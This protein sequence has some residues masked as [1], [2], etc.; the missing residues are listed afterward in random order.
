MQEIS[1]R[2]SMPWTTFM[3]TGILR[4]KLKWTHPC[5]PFWF[6]D[7]KSPDRKHERYGTWTTTTGFLTSYKTTVSA[8]VWRWTSRC[9]SCAPVPRSFYTRTHAC[10]THT[11]T[12]APSVVITKHVQFKLIKLSLRGKP[13]H[14]SR[15][16]TR[17]DK[18]KI[19]N[20]TIFR[21]VLL[22]SRFPVA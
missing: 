14:H 9:N 21:K 18:I 16:I 17:R 15:V 8:Q 5:L 1:G 19:Y 10:S 6:Q 22:C 4:L 11:H 13:R 3:A 20:Q 7:L 2:H 12:H